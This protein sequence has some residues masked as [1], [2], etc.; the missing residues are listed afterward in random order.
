MKGLDRAEGSDRDWADD[1]F[2]GRDGELDR[3]VA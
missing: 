2:F 1:F 3:A